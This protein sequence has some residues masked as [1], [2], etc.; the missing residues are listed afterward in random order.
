MKQYTV[1]NLPQELDRA[2]RAKKRE[3]GQSLN[4]VVVETL[5]RGAGLAEEAVVYHDLDFLAGS[6]VEDP[7]CM[8][9]LEEQERVDQES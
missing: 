8:K 4:E 6:W 2:L 3:T 9:V 7:E 5:K 1:R